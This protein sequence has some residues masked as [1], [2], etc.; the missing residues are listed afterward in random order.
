[1]HLN[2]FFTPCE[3]EKDQN[4]LIIIRMNPNFGNVNDVI[5][6]S[7][8]LIDLSLKLIDLSLKLIDLSLKLIDLS[9]KLIDLSLKFN[10]II[11]RAISGTLPLHIWCINYA[12]SL[13][14]MPSNMVPLVC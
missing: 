12:C 3:C 7:L 8:K 13:H 10:K 1:M 11:S 9:L 6:L 4:L 2:V 5:D 14:S